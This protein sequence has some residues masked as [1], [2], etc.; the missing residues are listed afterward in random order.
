MTSEDDV[1]DFHMATLACRWVGTLLTSCEHECLLSDRTL[2]LL[3]YN[4]HILMDYLVQDDRGTLHRDND[5]RMDSACSAA[6]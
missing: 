1:H 6:I 4:V 3:A 5:N 2:E